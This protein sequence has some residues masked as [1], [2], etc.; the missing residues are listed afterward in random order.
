MRK[1]SSLHRVRRKN[2]PNGVVVRS[3]AG[4]DTAGSACHRERMDQ[5]PTPMNAMPAISFRVVVDT[6]RVMVEPNITA[7]SVETTRAL[8]AAIKT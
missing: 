3:I 7:S 5:I 2:V 6:K 1:T 8:D 4:N